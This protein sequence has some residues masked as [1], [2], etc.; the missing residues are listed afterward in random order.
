MDR[1]GGS[2]QWQTHANNIEDDFSNAKC[3]RQ[4]ESNIENNDVKLGFDMIGVLFWFSSFICLHNTT[5]YY[6]FSEI[7]ALGMMHFETCFLV[8]KSAGAKL[9]A[10][11]R[12]T[13]QTIEDGKRTWRKGLQFWY[14]T[15]WWQRGTWKEYRQGNKGTVKMN[16]WRPR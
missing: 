3:Q 5:L 1:Q 9:L 6:Y 10:N 16:P 15:E 4:L 13:T 8:M 12:R 7:L 14:E 11:K 2:K